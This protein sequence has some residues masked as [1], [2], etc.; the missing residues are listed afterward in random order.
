VQGDNV[1]SNRVQDDG[2][3]RIA[4]SSLD[5]LRPRP[6]RCVGKSRVAREEL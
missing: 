1:Q 3:Q 2:V 4:V 6:G 5:A